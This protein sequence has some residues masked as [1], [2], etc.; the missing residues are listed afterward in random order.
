MHFYIGTYVYVSYVYVCTCNIYGYGYNYTLDVEGLLHEDCSTVAE[1]FFLLQNS[2]IS[3]N[4]GLSS[5]W[6]L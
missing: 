2:N 3:V 4:V 1:I 6:I 5:D